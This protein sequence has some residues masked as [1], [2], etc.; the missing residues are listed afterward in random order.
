MDNNVVFYLLQK[1]RR[2]ITG[3]FNICILGN[4]FMHFLLPTDLSYETSSRNTIRVSSGFDLRPIG[5]QM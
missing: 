5:L 4:S 2:T 3:I 1:K